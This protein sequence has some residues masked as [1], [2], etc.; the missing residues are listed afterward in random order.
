MRAATTTGDMS[1]RH[2]TGKGARVPGPDP[3]ASYKLRYAPAAAAR[4]RQMQTSDLREVSFAITGAHLHKTWTAYG[5]CVQG[6]PP[7]WDP[8]F[9]SEN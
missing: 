9:V 5:R 8:E 2:V 1:M 6:G 4:Q 3:N 7:V